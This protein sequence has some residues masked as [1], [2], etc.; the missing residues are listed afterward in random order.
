MYIYIYIQDTIFSV[1]LNTHTSPYL[2]GSKLVNKPG[3]KTSTMRFGKSLRFVSSSFGSVWTCGTPKTWW[4]FKDVLPSGKR[5]HK[6]DKIH[7]A[8]NG[9]AQYFDWAIFNSCV[10]L[11]ESSSQE[12]WW[13]ATDFFGFDRFQ[14]IQHDDFQH[15]LL[16]ETH[17]L[18]EA[19]LAFSGALLLMNLGP[20][21][22][23][24]SH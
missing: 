23:H 1:F 6:S 10:K 14:I 15:G 13:S 3:L 24:A 11:P 18:A 19:C 9:K 17:S 4:V 12:K 5:L 8:I 7:H 16:W 2:E 22:K 21:P 20:P